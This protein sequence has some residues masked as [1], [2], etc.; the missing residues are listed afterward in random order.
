MTKDI[1]E[2][3]QAILIDPAASDWL[4]FALKTALVADPVEVL[5]DAEAL[6]EVLDSRL[7]L[8]LKGSP[9]A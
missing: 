1:D 7:E 2:C 9:C 8:I 3:I 6:V 4:K 5:H